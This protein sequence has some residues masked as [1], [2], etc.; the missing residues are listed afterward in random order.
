M[1]FQESTDVKFVVSKPMSMHQTMIELVDSRITTVMNENNIDIS[2]KDVDVLIIG[3]GSN[4]TY[5]KE[6]QNM[7]K[8]H[9]KY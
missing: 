1:K 2:K 6:F 3:H 8:N 7:R 9:Q 4:Q 5:N